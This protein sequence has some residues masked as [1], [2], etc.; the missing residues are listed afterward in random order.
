[1]W[2]TVITAAF[3]Q[4]S[5][6]HLMVNMIVLWSFGG[7]LERLWGH[8][9]YVIFYLVAAVVSSLAHCFVSTVML[10]LGNVG[11]LG[12]SGVMSGLLL[13]FALMF[14]RHKILLFAVLPLPAL[15]AALLFVAFDIW[16]LVAQGQGVGLPIGHGAHLGGALCGA[17]FYFSYLKGRFGRTPMGGRGGRRGVTVE[18]TAEEAA[19]FDRLR[20]KLDTEGPQALTPKEQEFMRRLRERALGSG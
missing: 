18:L 3:S 15:A 13:A 4:Q 20:A 8:R 10:G 17:V 9:V 2:W 14:P 6:V 11:A 1:M 5:L 7:V 16:G 19:E 12:A